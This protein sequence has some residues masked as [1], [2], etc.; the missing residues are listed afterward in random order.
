VATTGSK[1]R[2]VFRGAPDDLSA[3]LPLDVPVPR[4]VPVRVAIGGKGE[5]RAFTASAVPFDG[6]VLLSLVLPRTTPP[7]H[8]DGVARLGEAEIEAELAVAPTVDLEIEPETVELR[9]NAGE[10]ATQEF[11]LYNAGNVAVEIRSGHAAGLFAEGGVERS[12]HRAYTAKPDESQR[13]VDFLGDLLA[14]EHG[15]LL[16]IRIDEGAGEIGSGETR[17]LRVTFEAPAGHLLAGRLYTGIWPLHDLGI[18]VRLNVPEE[19]LR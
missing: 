15:G 11:T 2:L 6:R 1:L 14:G 16:R 9:L 17:T 8:Y 19:T 5:E 3:T 4:R 12:L 10:R 7:G 18:D 13:R